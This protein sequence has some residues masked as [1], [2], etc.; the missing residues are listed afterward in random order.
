MPDTPTLTQARNDEALLRRLAAEALQPEPWRH[1]CTGYLGTC[2]KCGAKVSSGIEFTGEW[3]KPCGY[4]SPDT[5]PMPVIVSDLLKKVLH[6]AGS[7]PLRKAICRFWGIHDSRYVWAVTEIET[8]LRA[9]PI[10]QLLCCLIAL[11]KV[12]VEDKPDLPDFDMSTD[13]E[14][15]L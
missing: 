11:G 9:D 4:P 8:W 14:S 12:H 3:G 7:D 5:R 10:D 2:S 13:V 6:D 1:D 15:A